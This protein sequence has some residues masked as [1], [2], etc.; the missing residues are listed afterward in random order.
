MVKRCG[1]LFASD[2][3]VARARAGGSGGG[4][5]LNTLEYANL[6]QCRVL[7]NSA[8]AFGGGISARETLRLDATSLLISHNNATT[9]GGL[10]MMGSNSTQ[11]PTLFPC[12][13]SRLV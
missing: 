8:G 7:E 9:G 6:T 3:E 2:L 1:Q 11:V 5:S 10:W 4:F 12:N 13:N